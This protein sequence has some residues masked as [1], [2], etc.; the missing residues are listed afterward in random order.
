[1]DHSADMVQRAERHINRALAEGASGT[2]Q[3]GRTSMQ[4]VRKLL[5]ALRTSPST[6]QQ[7]NGPPLVKFL[8][9]DI[10]EKVSGPGDFTAAVHIQEE[11]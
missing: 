11:D 3:E 10:V 6:Q 7:E 9:G 5:A 1:M 2:L 8:L 4:M